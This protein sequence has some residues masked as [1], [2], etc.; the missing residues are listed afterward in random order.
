MRSI[1]GFVLYNA[2]LQEHA[3]A[4]EGKASRINLGAVVTRDLL[5]RTFREKHGREGI[6][7]KFDAAWLADAELLVVDAEAVGTSEHELTIDDFI[8]IRE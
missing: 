6:E 3:W 4:L 8:L 7:P 2:R 5:R 1:R